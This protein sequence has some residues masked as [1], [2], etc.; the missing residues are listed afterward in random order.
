MSF[1]ADEPRCRA[2]RALAPA[3][4][5]RDVEGPRARV[6]HRP[7]LDRL[8]VEA[9]AGLARRPAGRRRE[10]EPIRRSSR[11]RPASRGARGP[12]PAGRRRRARR[13]R[14]GGPR[15]GGRCPRRAGARARASRLSRPGRGCRPSAR[16]ATGPRRHRGRAASRSAAA[17][18][19]VAFGRV[20]ADANPAPRRNA[21][22][23]FGAHRPRGGVP[24]G[25]RK[26]D[27]RA[28]ARVVGA[29]RRPSSVLPPRGGC[30][31]GRRAAA[32]RR[33]TA[34]RSAPDPGAPAWGRARA[35]RRRAPGRRRPCSSR[36]RGA[37]RC[38]RRARRDPSRR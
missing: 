6:G 37:G 38:G 13:R 17:I 2:E 36:G 30:G 26:A 33:R 22:E 10:A 7:G 29:H 11:P 9:G 12:R 23:S 21:L 8:L 35:G 1:V 32:P 5:A 4:V 20:Q 16:R 25:R 28:G 3:R 34:G 27:E 19:A 15:R 24:D 18:A 14:R 31:S